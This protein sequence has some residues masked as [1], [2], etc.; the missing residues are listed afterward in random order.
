MT[1]SIERANIAL[2][3][4]ERVPLIVG[5]DESM[6]GKLISNKHVI[7]AE[8]KYYYTEE[9]CLA[10]RQRSTAGCPTYGNCNRC[11]RSGPVGLMCSRCHIQNSVYTI[12]TTQRPHESHLVMDAEYLGR[13]CGQGHE[14]AM[15][16]RVP[17]WD[18][19]PTQFLA[20][21]DCFM[22]MLKGHLDLEDLTE[23]RQL[24]LEAYRDIKNNVFKGKE[25]KREDHYAFT[26]MFQSWTY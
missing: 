1:S 20:M 24:R 8:N 19:P 6:C 4:K 18:E 3:R 9:E 5:Y 21:D 10:F 15:A 22:V 12:M 26:P 11:F 2:N 25:F 16:D 13:L 7:R 23:Q 14:D 17:N